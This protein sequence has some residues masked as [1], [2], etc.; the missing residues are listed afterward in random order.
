VKGGAT[1]DITKA[2]RDV[3]FVKDA[4][5]DDYHEAACAIQETLGTKAN[6]HLRTGHFEKTIVQFHQNLAQYLSN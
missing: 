4:V 1:A 2:K 5:L 6:Q 3:S